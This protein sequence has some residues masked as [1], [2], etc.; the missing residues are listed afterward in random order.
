MSYLT[1][2]LLRSTPLNT[3]SSTLA[4]V[5]RLTTDPELSI[6]KQA[7]IKALRRLKTAGIF[8]L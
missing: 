1:I 6:I 4:V 5:E 3:I 7:T 8:K 2:H